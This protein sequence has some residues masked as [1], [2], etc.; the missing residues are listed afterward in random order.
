[1]LYDGFYHSQYI[2]RERRRLCSLSRTEFWC[3]KAFE[4]SVKEGD[5]MWSKFW[6]KFWSSNFTPLT[7]GGS[8]SE[9][10]NPNRKTRR[11]I[12]TDSTIAFQRATPFQDRIKTRKVGFRVFFLVK[13]NASQ[14]PAPALLKGYLQSL[15]NHFLY[16]KNINFFI[17]IQFNSIWFIC[18]WWQ[19][20]TQICLLSHRHQGFT[21]IHDDT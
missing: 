18:A 15:L 1:M 3:P 2:M 7:S 6:S 16:K 20:T 14:P 19:W 10:K 21:F 17:S 13:K 4:P 11:A 12:L 8:Y 5:L 9:L